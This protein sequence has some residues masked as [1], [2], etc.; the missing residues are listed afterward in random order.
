MFGFLNTFQLAFADGF[1]ERSQILPMD[2]YRTGGEM[3]PQLVFAV[4]FHGGEQRIRHKT[5]FPIELLERNVR[6]RFAR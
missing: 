3:E 1:P 5:P 2:G 4:K 6:H